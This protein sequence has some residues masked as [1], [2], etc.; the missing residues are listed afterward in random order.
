MRTEFVA[1]RGYSKEDWEAVENPDLTQDEMAAARPFRDVFPDMANA[2]E[3][4]I[5]TRGRPRV[6][7]PKQAV[8]LR[9]DPDVIAMFKSQGDDWR[10]RMSTALKK[11]AGL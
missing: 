7:A 4:A 2:M 6:P 5:A 8:T 10:G 1:G 3:K 9:L 11:A